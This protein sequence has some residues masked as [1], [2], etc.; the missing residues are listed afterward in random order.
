MQGAHVVTH[1]WNIDSK[2][3][4]LFQVRK[5]FLRIYAHRLHNE[6][7]IR[8]ISK[9]RSLLTFPLATVEGESSTTAALRRRLIGSPLF[10]GV[11]TGIRRGRPTASS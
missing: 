10:L 11:L 5:I 2:F 4:K 9:Y 1:E 8:M 6:A 3:S 7:S